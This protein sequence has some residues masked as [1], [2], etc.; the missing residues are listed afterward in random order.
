MVRL[1]GR[2]VKRRVVTHLRTYWRSSIQI[3]QPEGGDKLGGNCTPQVEQIC[4]TSGP[5]FGTRGTAE[6]GTGNE[7]W[8]TLNQN[9]A[10]GSGK[11][12]QIVER[13]MEHGRKWSVHYND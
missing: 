2:E 3:L 6:A 8:M 10:P 4:A 1:R 11:Q 7:N 12:I 9:W 5:S 13:R